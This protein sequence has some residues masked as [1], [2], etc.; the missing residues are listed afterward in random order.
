MTIFSGSGLDEVTGGA[1]GVWLE[2]PPEPPALA[3]AANGSTEPAGGPTSRGVGS[4]FTPIASANGSLARARRSALR[5]LALLEGKAAVVVVG[6][7][8]PVGVLLPRTSFRSFG[9]SYASTAS[10]T[11]P[12]TPAMIFWRRCF[13]AAAAAYAE[14]FCGDTPTDDIYGVAD[15]SVVVVGATGTA[16]GA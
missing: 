5:S 2:V 3:V 13:A 11:T 4:A 9:T 12:S 1:D 8:S 16:V 10:S 14:R 6:T 15:E 7:T